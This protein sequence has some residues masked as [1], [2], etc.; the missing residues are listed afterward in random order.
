MRIKY[1]GP[2]DAVEVSGLGVVERDAE[3]DCPEGLAKSLLEQ[4]DNWQ[5]VKAPAKTKEA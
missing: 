3:A 4:A 1:V 2:H 5:P